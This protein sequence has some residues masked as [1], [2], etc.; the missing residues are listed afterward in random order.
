MSGSRRGAD[1][2]CEH[3]VHRSWAFDGSEG[4]RTERHDQDLAGYHFGL[5]FC[6]RRSGTDQT[7]I[8]RREVC[9]PVDDNPVPADED[10]EKQH[11]P[12][13]CSPGGVSGCIDY[14]HY[15][16]LQ[17]LAETISKAKLLY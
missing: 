8:M 9:V 1:R 16:T 14:S 2:D 3:P 6:L 13:G 15:S 11:D 4:Q 17:G 10:D 7:G 12:D 5:S